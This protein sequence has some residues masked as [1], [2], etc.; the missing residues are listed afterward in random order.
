MQSRTGKA[1]NVASTAWRTLKTGSLATADAII[2]LSLMRKGARPKPGTRTAWPKGLRERLYREQ[3]GL[4]TYCIAT[5]AHPSSPPTPVIPA[6]AG[7]QEIPSRSGPYRNRPAL[8]NKQQ[9][10]VRSW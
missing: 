3:N 2:A 4:C 6:E 1:G 10:K 9:R 8:A 5:S 7:I